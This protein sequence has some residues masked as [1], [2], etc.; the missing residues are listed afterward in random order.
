MNT[1][2]KR[3]K[4]KYVFFNGTGKMVFVHADTLDSC[5]T[6]KFVIAP[7]EEAVFHRPKGTYP[8]AK[9]VENREKRMELYV[10]AVRD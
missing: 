6:N 2:E 8:Y 3:G 10:R 4:L 1:S 5:T 9:V 7:L